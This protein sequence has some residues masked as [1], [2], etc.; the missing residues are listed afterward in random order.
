[1]TKSIMNDLN[2]AVS[3]LRDHYA[4]KKTLRTHHV[5]TPKNR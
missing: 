4:G 3:S 1:M 2:E 5:P